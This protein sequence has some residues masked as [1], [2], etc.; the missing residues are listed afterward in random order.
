MQEKF[1]VCNEIADILQIPKNDRILMQ[2]DITDEILIDSIVDAL[3]AYGFSSE[4]QEI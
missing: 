2:V 3:V 4:K 1:V